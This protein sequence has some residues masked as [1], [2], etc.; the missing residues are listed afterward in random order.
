V[1]AATSCADDTPSQISAQLASDQAATQLNLGYL[2]E[3]RS[4]G[5]GRQRGDGFE[6]RSD[7]SGSVRTARS[8]LISAWKQLAPAASSSDGSEHAA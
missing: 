4:D 5:A 7:A 6:L 3:P 1:G 8:L 2:T